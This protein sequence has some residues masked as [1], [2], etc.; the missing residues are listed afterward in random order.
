MKK[1]QGL[2]ITTIVV[3]AIAL[4]V[5]V[6]LVAVFTGQIGAKNKALKACDTI[7]GNCWTQEQKESQ[8][9][10]D[11]IYVLDP[12]KTCSGSTED[13]PIYCYVKV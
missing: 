1:G 7:Q 4:L 5:L 11:A 2:S 8:S 12:T 13:L 9:G 3:A 10:D 6:V